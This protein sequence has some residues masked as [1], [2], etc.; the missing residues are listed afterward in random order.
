MVEREVDRLNRMVGNLLDLSRIEAGALRPRKEVYPL[1]AVVD[2][3]VARVAPSAPDHTVVVD[4]PDEL[5]PVP[6]DY[7][8]VDQVLTNLVENA[9]RH[10][11][12]GTEV[13]VSAR[14]TDGVV[15]VVVADN[16]PG[17]PEA[18]LERIFEKFYR[19]PNGDGRPHGGSGLGL[20]V[21]RGLIEAH[22]GRAWAEAANGC[23][24]AVHFT[25]PLDGEPVEEGR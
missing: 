13:Q 14:R 24:L 11:P 18:A 25:L 16:G 17:V 15:E 20:A 4:V 9:F 7:V 22:G 1:A 3:V 10:T 2:D 19:A 5:P 21:V 6:L 8:Q 12:P 23:G